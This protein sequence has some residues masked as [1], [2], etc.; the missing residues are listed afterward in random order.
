MRPFFAFAALAVTLAASGC[1][2]V[3]DAATPRPQ[4]D[5]DKPQRT[6]RNLTVTWDNIG[7]GG[8]A[9]RQPGFVD[10]LA[11]E[12]SFGPEQNYMQ[13]PTAKTTSQ[14]KPVVLPSHPS[15][16]PSAPTTTATPT[17]KTSSNTSYSTYE[18]QRWQRYCNDGVGMTEQDWKFVDAQKALVPDGAFPACRPPQHN[19]HQYLQAWQS[20]CAGTAISPSQM[21]VV[22]NS[23]RPSSIKAASCKGNLS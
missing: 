5:D 3:P 10:V 17:V 7:R 19:A 23:A 20:F 12:Q 2:T 14:V 8:A 18:L 15:T 16:T 11:T 22:R 4:P 6:S 21:N 13:S 9:M 1:V